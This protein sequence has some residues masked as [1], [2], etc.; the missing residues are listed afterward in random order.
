MIHI[1]LQR[2]RIDVINKRN[3]S[4]SFPLILPLVIQISK[5]I[6]Q[7]NRANNLSCNLVIRIGDE[8]NLEVKND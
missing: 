6:Y 3:L 5:L 4:L 1:S 2:N 8:I 7:L